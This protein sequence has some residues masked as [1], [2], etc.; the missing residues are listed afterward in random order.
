[1]TGSIAQ[2]QVLLQLSSP[3]CQTAPRIGSYASLV[4]LVELA[5]FFV[6]ASDLQSLNR[7]GSRPAPRPK[8]LS[9][10]TKKW[11]FRK[12]GEGE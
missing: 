3:C 9:N 7:H 2:L 8:M 11:L 6:M 12:F 5:G 1:M 4:N 10:R